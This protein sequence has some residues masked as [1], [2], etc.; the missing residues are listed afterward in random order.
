MY[1][2]HHI[3]SFL[4]QGPAP[5]WW[6]FF[7]HFIYPLSLY[8]NIYFFRDWLIIL[9]SWYITSIF[10]IPTLTMAEIIMKQQHSKK[11]GH[12]FSR[13]CASLV[14]QQCAQIYIL[15]RYATM[16]VCW[17]FQGDDEVL[18]LHYIWPMLIYKGLFSLGVNLASAVS[19]SISSSSLP[20][21]VLKLIEG[22][23]MPLLRLSTFHI[24]ALFSYTIFYLSDWWE[25][26]TR[27]FGHLYYKGEIAST[28]CI[29]IYAF[30]NTSFVPV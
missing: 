20:I 4:P 3:S 28:K 16:L 30:S 11:K 6:G 27:L 5:L 15:R 7:S 2:Y 1:K 14:K 23:C 24:C 19:F 26:I 18:I 12:G 29:V 21:R 17:Y 25:S 22:R 8:T 10:Y 13:K 9:Q